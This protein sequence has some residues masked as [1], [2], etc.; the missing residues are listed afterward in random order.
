MTPEELR[1]RERI[2]E[3][4]LNNVAK[5]LRRFQDKLDLDTRNAAVQ[6]LTS[7]LTAVRGVEVASPYEQLA[8]ATTSMLEHIEQVL[9]S[10]GQHHATRN[11]CLWVFTYDRLK[12]DEVLWD[13]VEELRVKL[14][15]VQHAIGVV[16]DIVRPDKE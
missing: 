10:V 9:R 5:E 11:R 13:D 8:L 3:D 2:I 1:E 7:A 14:W 12:Y 6:S 4:T 16:A 15:A